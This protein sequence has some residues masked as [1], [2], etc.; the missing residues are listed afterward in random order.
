MYQCPEC[1]EK[2]VWLTDQD[3]GGI[4]SNEY[5]C[6]TCDIEVIKYREVRIID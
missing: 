2:L 6:N 1:K 5:Y 4:I 3:N